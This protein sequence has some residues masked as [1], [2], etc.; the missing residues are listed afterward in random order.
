VTIDETLL[1]GKG[2]PVIGVNAPVLWF[3]T[4]AAMPGLLSSPTYTYCPEGSVATNEG[5]GEAAKGE[6]GTAVR[7]PVS[8]SMENADTE[9][10]LAVFALFATNK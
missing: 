7:T 6:P 2:D 8:G 1:P 4:N 10:P 3:I 9:F 5:K